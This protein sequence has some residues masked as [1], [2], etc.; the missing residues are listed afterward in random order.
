MCQISSQYS[1]TARSD[2]KR[3]ERAM[4]TSDILF[5]FVALRFIERGTLGLGG[6]WG[7][8]AL[9]GNAGKAQ[10]AQAKRGWA[11]RGNNPRG[12]WGAAP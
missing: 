3:P 11:R 8:L 10:Q 12:V 7:N 9:R 2:E 5:H 1:C 4:L 6:F